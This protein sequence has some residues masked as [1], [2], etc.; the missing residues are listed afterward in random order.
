MLFWCSGFSS[1]WSSIIAHIRLWTFP[2]RHF[3]YLLPYFFISMCVPPCIVNSSNSFFTFLSQFVF[4]LCISVWSHISL[5]K[6][7]LSSTSGITLSLY[8]LS[9][10]LNNLPWLDSNKWFCL[11]YS[12]LLSYL[13]G[14][15]P[16]ANNLCRTSSWTISTPFYFT[17]NF[18][19]SFDMTPW[20][21]SSLGL[22]L[23]NCPNT[24]RNALCFSKILCHQ[25]GC[26][27]SVI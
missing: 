14:F 17:V 15:A 5:Q 8:V 22:I 26:L 2:V 10:W 25:F 24:L 21:C 6:L 7:L 23:F 27:F 13:S 20:F 19:S 11:Y 9:N 1:L 3:S 16:T 4:S 18:L 12:I